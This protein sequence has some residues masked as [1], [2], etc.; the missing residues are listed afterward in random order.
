MRTE[1]IGRAGK[2]YPQRAPESIA[3]ILV[4]SVRVLDLLPVR[5]AIAILALVS[6][7]AGPI[8]AWPVEGC[9]GDADCCKSG[10]CPMHPE[11]AKSQD[12]DEPMPCHHAASAPE[13]VSKC[14]VSAQCTGQARQLHPAPLP[15]GVLSAAASIPMP[16]GKCAHM[17]SLPIAPA[18]GF[19]PVPFEPPRP[20]A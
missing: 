3:R 12:A 11:H 8:A 15:H 10:I 1:A 6:L 9:C 17:E 13:P 18:L 7:V 19:D 4:R 2:E 16:A 20:I 5:R 14:K